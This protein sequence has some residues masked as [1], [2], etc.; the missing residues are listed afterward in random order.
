MKFPRSTGTITLTLIGF[1]LIGAAVKNHLT[2]VVEYSFDK[3]QRLLRTAEFVYRIDASKVSEE[4]RAQLEK[5]GATISIS[6]SPGKV[7]GAWPVLPSIEAINKNLDMQ[8][9][10]Q[11]AI[12]F[13]NQEFVLRGTLLPT[14][15]DKESFIQING[16]IFRFSISDLSLGERKKLGSLKWVTLRVPKSSMR[17]AWQAVPDEPRGIERNIASLSMPATE[18][19]FEVRDKWLSITGIVQHSFEEKSFLLQSGDV[20]FAF[21][22]STLS[23][24]EAKDFVLPGK[25]VALK[26]P[27]TEVSL[28]WT[29]NSNSIPESLIKAI[30]Q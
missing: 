15:S 25:R 21:N 30:E 7:V 17:L 14:T 5:V 4:E 3:N 16:T 6:L 28:V 2:G 19:H 1:L 9:A 27:V 11:D 12:A 10:N 22:K 20:F 18:D 29:Q 13:E 26:I 23:E 24:Q 8:P